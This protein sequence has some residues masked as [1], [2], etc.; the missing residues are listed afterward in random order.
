MDDLTPADTEA[1]LRGYFAAF[2]NEPM[3]E[4]ET[5][6]WRDGWKFRCDVMAEKAERRLQCTLH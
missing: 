1:F 5:P 4:N 2:R 6:A 3:D